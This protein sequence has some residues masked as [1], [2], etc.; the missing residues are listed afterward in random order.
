MLVTDDLCSFGI[1]GPAADLGRLE[2]D[3]VGYGTRTF[4]ELLAMAGRRQVRFATR[5][6]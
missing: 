3:G 6:S 2:R 5:D 4:A 1:E